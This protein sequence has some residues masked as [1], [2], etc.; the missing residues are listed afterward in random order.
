M[1]E[2]LVSFLCSQNNNVKR[3]GSN[4]ESIKV[5]Y[6]SEIG[7]L[8]GKVWFAFPT[9]EQLSKAKIE[10]LT[11]LGLGYRAKYIVNS[12]KSIVEKGGED[13]LNSLRELSYE[14]SKSELM[15]LDGVGPKVAD[16]IC[17]FGL[18]HLGTVPLDVHM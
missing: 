8:Y 11:K 3:I 15:A 16:C 9:P 5:K 14:E 1:F 12:V 17:L 13:W 10:E 4:I 7:S 2:C 6:G 18:N